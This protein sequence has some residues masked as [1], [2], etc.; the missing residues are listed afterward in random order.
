MDFSTFDLVQVAGLIGGLAAGYGMLR[1]TVANNNRRLDRLTAR[2]DR[3]DERLIERQEADSQILE[4][5]ARVETLA[6]EIK[7]Q[8]RDFMRRG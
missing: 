5:L 7:E 6:T 4:R 2:V 8:I 3:V 1:A